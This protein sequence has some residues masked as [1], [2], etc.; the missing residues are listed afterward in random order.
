MIPKTMRYVTY[1]EGGGPEVLRIV[2]GQTPEIG[3]HEVLIQ[4]HFAGVNRP[5]ILQRAGNYPPPPGASP[6]LGLEVAGQVVAHGAE[7]NTWKV[8]DQ[9]CALTP[10][11]GYAEYCRTDA[12]HCL[13]LPR[14]FDLATSAAIP[15]NFFTVWTNLIDRGRLQSGESVLIHG[16]S[17]GIGY[18]AVQIAKQ[19]GAI[20]FTTVGNEE[21]VKFCRDLG[22]DH[23]FNY[24]TGDFVAQIKRIT[25]ER[26]VDIVLDMVGG[27]YIEKNVSLLANEG[28]LVQIAFLQGSTISNFNFLPIM[29]R[30][31]TITGSTLRPRT[32]EEKASIANALGEHVWP[33][34]ESRR[35]KIVVYR[36]FPLSEVAEAH[37]MMERSEHTGKL[38]LSFGF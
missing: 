32:V 24:R 9:V 7:V 15:E 18:T 6:I 10:G 12:S 16:G 27:P 14:G 29:V 31:L 25:R 19:F 37:R 38:V 20:V 28:R 11:G 4:T 21:K 17:S 26:G 13:A 23:V 30:R 5:D 22:A 2:E 34:L 33:L 35:I 36:I 3:P 8:G 1:G